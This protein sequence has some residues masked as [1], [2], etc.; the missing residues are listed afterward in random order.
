MVSWEYKSL[1]I[2]KNEFEKRANELGGEG[3]EL[4]NLVLDGSL[5]QCVFKRS[6]SAVKNRCKACKDPIS[7]GRDFCS[8]ECADYYG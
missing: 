8:K 5:Y 2:Y 3:W 6:K 7:I 1:S 4:V